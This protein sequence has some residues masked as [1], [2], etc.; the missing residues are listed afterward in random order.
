MREQY[1]IDI[2]ETFLG[3]PVTVCGWVN[4]RRDHGGVIF[5]D[6]RDREGLLQIIFNPENQ[7]VFREA[8]TLR[9]ETII[10][11]T[12]L[13]RAR[14]EGMINAE[15]ATGNI[16]L[17]ASELTILSIPQATLP[18]VLDDEKVSEEVRLKYRY[19]DLRSPVMQ[20]N[21]RFRAKVN[22]FIRNYFEEH[23]FIE[24]ETPMMTKTTPEGSRDYLV[25]SRVYKGKFYALPQSPQLF[26]QLLMMAGF[27][28]Y[29]QIVRCFR[30]EDLRADR[31]PEF[32][33]L[34][35]EMAFSDEAMI[36]NVAETMVRD[37]FKKLLNID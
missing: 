25:P 6:L 31:Q 28:K 30:D 16:E 7:V 19:L 3:K 24:V 22:H 36:K 35:V 14:P 21:I 26:K 32:T 33:Q 8:E 23:G 15:I 11:V 17:V 18:F 10:C 9:S 34:D 37:A 13:V 1:S 4:K 12:G 29:Y 2:N 27:D 5:V 20:R